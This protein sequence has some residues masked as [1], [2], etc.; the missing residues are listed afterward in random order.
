MDRERYTNC[1]KPFITGSGKSPEERR[2]SFCAGAKVCSGKAKDAKEAVHICQTEPPK[3]PKEPKVGGTRRVGKIDPVVLATCIIQN[4]DGEF[5]S[6]NLS[7]AI[8]NCTDK[9]A[10]KSPAETKRIFIRKCLKE[11]AV[12]GSMGETAKNFKVCS[13]TWKNQEEGTSMPK[14]EVLVAST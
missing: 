11:N 7:V 2:L 10:P 3:P 4:I 5:S 6:H 12:T 9:R 13:L 1:M 14:E 8:A